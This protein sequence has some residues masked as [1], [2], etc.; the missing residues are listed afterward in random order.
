MY[1]NGF[2]LFLCDVLG[3]AANSVEINIS[4]LGRLLILNKDKI[5][6]WFANTR[7]ADELLFLPAIILCP[8]GTSGSNRRQKT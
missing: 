7:S 3:K 4:Y 8:L 5:T 1:L 6:S 2:L